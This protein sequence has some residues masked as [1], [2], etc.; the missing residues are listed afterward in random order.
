M[1]RAIDQLPDNYRDVLLLWAIEDMKYREIA[2]I[3]GIPIG[4]V[5]SRLFRAR[6]LL[7]ESLADVATEQRLGAGPEPTVAGSN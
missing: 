7:A 6:Q 2:E 1:K 3:T 4:T 5:M